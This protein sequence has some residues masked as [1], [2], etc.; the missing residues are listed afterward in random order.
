M[1]D[2]ESSLE[3]TPAEG[4]ERLD[5][6]VADS[7]P[8]LSRSAVQRLI[9]NEDIQVNGQPAKASL[10]L[11]AG[12]RVRVTLPPDET[13]E[14]IQPE[15]IPLDVL[16]EDGDLAAVNKPAGMVVHPAYGHRTG[17]LVNA[18]LARWPEMAAVGGLERAGIV[19]R[20]DKD[21]SGVIAL[22]KSTAA[23]EALQ[24][25]FKA[26]TVHK[27]YLALVEGVPSTPSGL[28]DAPIGRD[29]KQRKRMAVRHD[30]RKALTRYTLLEDFDTNALLE[31]ELLTGRT[32]QI[33]IHLAWMGHPVVGDQVYGFRKQ[34]IKMK[35]LFLHAAELQVDSPT[36]GERL[37]FEATL[38][39]GLQNTLDKLRQNQRQ[40]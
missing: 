7:L 25:Q 2:S 38:P 20:L 29:Q 6:F 33:R 8:Q 13:T 40:V 19:H 36:S 12:D 37:T 14:D 23:L 39:A 3:L 16:Y 9:K 10:R 32:H 18:A 11:E 22:A 30:G 26:R 28:I 21:T 17:T 24:A 5:R 4:G 1:A 27:R 31:L 15:A 35:R 34:R